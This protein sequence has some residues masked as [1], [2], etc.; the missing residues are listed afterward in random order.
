MVR[1]M[2]P[3]CNAGDELSIVPLASCLHQLSLVH[4]RGADAVSTARRLDTHVYLTR[5]STELRSSCQAGCVS[6][7]EQAATQRPML[8]D[9]LASP[10]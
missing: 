6:I 10:S 7:C 4:R 8:S 2:R 9:L 3:L 5:N 1:E